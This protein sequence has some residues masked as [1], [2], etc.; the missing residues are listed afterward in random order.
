MIQLEKILYPTD[1]SDV[2]LHSLVYARALAE[3]YGAELHCI[4]VVDE[5][6]QY[7]ISMGPDTV[8]VGPVVDDVLKTSTEQMKRFVAEHLADVPFSVSS[9]VVV[10]RPFME[11]IR[12]ARELPADMIVLSTHGRTGLSHILLGSVAEKI[13]RK[14]PCP[15]LSIRHP[16][17]KFTMP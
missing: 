15:V 4:H 5:A 16:D 2:S 17:Y 8:P 3:Q 7:W 1:F 10:G 9:S 13:V 6:Y 12:Q 11:I 14:A